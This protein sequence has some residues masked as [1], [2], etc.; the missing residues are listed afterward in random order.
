[1]Y[2]PKGRD[3]GVEGYEGELS[4]WWEQMFLGKAKGRF[5]PQ[6]IDTFGIHGLP[7]VCPS[8]SSRNLYLLLTC[9]DAL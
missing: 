9:V 2:C 5:Y 3:F 7:V 4:P 1:L 8:L 6:L